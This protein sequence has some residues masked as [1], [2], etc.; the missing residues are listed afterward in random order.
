[1]DSIRLTCNRLGRSWWTTTETTQL[2]LLGGS[3]GTARTAQSCGG[4]MHAVGIHGKG[5]EY[6][7]SFGLLC[8]NVLPT[9]P[10][11]QAP[12]NGLNVTSK[13]PTFCWTN[14][15]RDL[16]RNT[17]CLSTSQTA[18]CAVSNAV[19]GE[20]D[21]TSSNWTPAQDLPYSRGTRV[22]WSVKACNDNGCRSGVSSFT[23]Y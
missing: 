2:S 12:I 7:D 14:A 6:V 1:V 4:A 9:T 23:A 18:D 11:L 10:S 19:K 15:T 20:I 21:Y 16:G 3:G 13:R 5:G 22:Y 17:V 8:G